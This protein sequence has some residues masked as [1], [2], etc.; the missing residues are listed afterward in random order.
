MN[1]YIDF[2]SEILSNPEDKKEFL[3]RANS[4]MKVL[5]AAK[6]KTVVS[7]TKFKASDDIENYLETRKKAYDILEENFRFKN[8]PKI[9]LGSEVVFSQDIINIKDI[10]R[11][12]IADTKYIMM[13]L[14]EEAY[15]EDTFTGI[16]KLIISKN[17]YPVIPCIEKYTD[18]YSIEQIKKLSSL[19]IL[20]QV[21]CQA[22]VNRTTRRL[23]L[24]LLNRGIAQIIGSE[25]NIIRES[26]RSAAEV[27]IDVL[28]KDI[29]S[30]VSD[31]IKPSP[32]YADAVR[33]M[34]YNLPIGKYKQIKNNAGMVISNAALKDIMISD[35]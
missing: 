18:T 33:I 9:L 23:A 27:V 4:I 14:P 13:T 24:D 20:M 11:L 21:S 3:S 34:R 35:L 16:Q 26:P 31:V 7:T 17:V 30:N 32:Q 22:I 6:I 10:N 8:Y 28:N 19:G 25:D 2:N 12:C 1:G 29:T 5:Q 15:S